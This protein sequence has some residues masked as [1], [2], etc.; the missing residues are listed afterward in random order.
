MVQATV[1]RNK[2][3]NRIGRSRDY[4]FSSLVAFSTKRRT[5]TSQHQGTLPRQ[6]RWQSLHHQLWLDTQLRWHQRAR[7]HSPEYPSL[8]IVYCSGCK[9]RHQTPHYCKSFSTVIFVR[10]VSA[11]NKRTFCKSN[12]KRTYEAL[13][14]GHACLNIEIIIYFSINWSYLLDYLAY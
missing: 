13:E 7:S 1:D 9:Q 8:P 11:V 10:Y 4:P 2:G 5:A 12:P 14:F 3:R 6:I